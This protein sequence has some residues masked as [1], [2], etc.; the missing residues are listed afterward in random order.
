MCCSPMYSAMK[1][2]RMQLNKNK[3]DM[4]ESKTI[5]STIHIGKDKKQL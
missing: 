1:W 5:K 4:M 2:K 3:K